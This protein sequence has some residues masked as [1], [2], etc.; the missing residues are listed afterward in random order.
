MSAH[1][2]SLGPSKA[3][4]MG[5][6]CSS[7]RYCSSAALTNCGWADGCIFFMVL[8][9]CL[10]SY[11][12][13]HQLLSSK[14]I[15]DHHTTT[16]TLCCHLDADFFLQSSLSFYNCESYKCVLA[17]P[18][19]RNISLFFFYIGLSQFKIWLF[20]FYPCLILTLL[21][22]WNIAVGSFVSI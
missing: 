13:M 10:I 17:F 18:N 5:T 12:T 9:T 19:F 4:S 16:T 14:A 3:V 7:F 2:F 20:V 15:P 21:Q 22:Y 8:L 6:D 11:R 1:T